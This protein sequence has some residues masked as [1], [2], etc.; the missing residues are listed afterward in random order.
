MVS[1]GEKIH[2][3]ETSEIAYFYAMNKSAF[4]TT[5]T[6]KS[7]PVEYSLDKLEELLKPEHYFRINRKYIINMAAI[8]KMYA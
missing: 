2:K 7:Y 8:D 5:F 6:N 3:V 4:L 1:Y